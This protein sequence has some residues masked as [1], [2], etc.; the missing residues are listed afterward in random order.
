M[1]LAFDFGSVLSSIEEYVFNQLIAGLFSGSLTVL[2]LFAI[3]LLF[4]FFI[5]FKTP[6]AFFSVFK[7]FFLL[8]IIIIS[9]FFFVT[10]L[11][12]R[13]HEQLFDAS[14][15]AIAVFGIVFTLVA[16]IVAAFAMKRKVK[17]L[18]EVEVPELNEI[19]VGEAVV[20]VQK[21]Q[22]L[23]VKEK[24]SFF[25]QYLK[26]GVKSIKSERS[27]LA[28]LS[29]VIIAE[30]GVFSTKTIA[31]PTIEIGLVFFALFFIG[32]LVFIHTS[33]K[34]KSQGLMH[35]LAT[36]VFAFGLSLILGMFWSNF[37]LETLLSINYFATD[38][39]VAC[40]TGIGLALVM[41]SRG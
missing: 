38:S 12:V 9:T 14:T 20:K 19:K 13:M 2:I 8:V 4:L 33:Y 17:G 15:I 34:S 41:G 31:A 37:A 6:S 7:R 32:A 1:F 3:V 27:L 5:F 39:L 22:P 25:T 16:F 30:F 40:I 24:Y 35:L 36:S 10:N 26:P 28:I 23:A 29:Y 21:T 11:S 18:E